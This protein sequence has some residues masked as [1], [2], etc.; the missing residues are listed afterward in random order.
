L[1]DTVRLIFDLSLIPP[2]LRTYYRVAY[3]Q[4]MNTAKSLRTAHELKSRILLPTYLRTS[5]LYTYSRRAV[6]NSLI[7]QISFHV[8]C[9]LFTLFDYIDFQFSR[10]M[11]LFHFLSKYCLLMM[12]SSRASNA[13]AHLKC[14]YRSMIPSAFTQLR[15]SCFALQYSNLIV[16]FD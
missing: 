10:E 12:I 14:H 5:R 3:A 16:Y 13:A 8:N 4:K 2:H 7:S 15:A 6:S 1:I 11:I 9:G